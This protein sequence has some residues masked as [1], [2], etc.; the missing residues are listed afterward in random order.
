[1]A[2][3]KCLISSTPSAC[4]RTQQE[5]RFTG[6][7]QS[8]KRSQH[9]Q[10]F[11]SSS[12]QSWSLRREV[13][14]HPCPEK[15]SFLRNFHAS[16][17]F[18]CWSCHEKFNCAKGLPRYSSIHIIGRCKDSKSSHCHQVKVNVVLLLFQRLL[19]LRYTNFHLKFLFSIL[20]RLKPFQTHFR[21]LCLPH[22]MAQDL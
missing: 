17:H 8:H 20:G 5:C 21:D 14:V 18:K 16:C 7:L 19:F 11:G 2:K 15:A 10:R 12:A 13:K 6:F 4:W 9:P 1:M 3:T 22:Y